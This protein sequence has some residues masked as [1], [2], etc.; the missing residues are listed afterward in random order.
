[1]IKLSQIIFKSKYLNILKDCYICK[2][3][4]QNSEKKKLRLEILKNIFEVII[5]SFP[6]WKCQNIVMHKECYTY[7]M[8]LHK[9]PEPT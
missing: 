2:A 5:Y 6:H 9:I 1:M 3:V 4:P 7:I 8:I